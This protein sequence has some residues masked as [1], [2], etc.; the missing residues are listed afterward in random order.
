MGI[1]SHVIIGS[2]VIARGEVQFAS[3]TLFF[4]FPRAFRV[5]ARRA[6][7]CHVA[8]CP[9]ARP[10][11]R[12]MSARA[13]NNRVRGRNWCN[14]ELC[15]PLIKRAAR[16]ALERPL[17]ELASVFAPVRTN[18]PSQTH[19]LP[20]YTCTNGHLPGDSVR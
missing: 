3:C 4:S 10:P 1:R 18:V 9:P 14:S 12:P 20:A 6:A 16:P 5:A 11:A 2:L 13:R 8:E 17:T 19:I 7:P 15:G